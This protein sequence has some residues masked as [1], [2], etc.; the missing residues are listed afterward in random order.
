VATRAGSAL[1][2]RRDV[3]AIELVICRYCDTVHRRIAPAG[4]EIMRCVTCD[5]PLYRGNGDLGAMLAVTV[6]AA[7]GFLVANALPLLT[8]TSGSHQT[9]ATLWRAVAASYDHELPFVAIALTLT[10]IVAPAIELG[11]LL[12]LLVPLCMRTRPLAFVSMMEVLR[13]LRPWRMVEVFFLGVI[14][15]VVKL[16]ALATALLG[17]GMFGVGVMAFALASLSSFDLGALWRRAEA[18]AS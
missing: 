8:L 12:W 7:I 16:S 18:V 17:W 10:L 11:V 5:S 1:A 15:A 2:P 13:T 9:R 14:V 4:R 6:T 3:P